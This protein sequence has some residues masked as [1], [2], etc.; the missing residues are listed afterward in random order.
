[1]R[2]EPRGADGGQ[3]RVRVRL[4]C[5]DFLLAI[6]VRSPDRYYVDPGQGQANT[7]NG[8]ARSVNCALTPPRPS[9]PSAT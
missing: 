5:K 6:L 4:R 1:M 9:H 7:D 2:V 3:S 8:Q